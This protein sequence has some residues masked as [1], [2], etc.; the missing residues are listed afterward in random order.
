MMAP[1][2][3]T[4]S[5]LQQHASIKGRSLFGMLTAT[6]TL[7]FPSRLIMHAIVSSEESSRERDQLP[8]SRMIGRFD[9]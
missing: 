7:R 1:D 3:G 2:H 4:E 5:P 6:P 8:V 9:C